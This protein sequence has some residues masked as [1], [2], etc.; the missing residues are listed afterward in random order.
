MIKK[1]FTLLFLLISLPVCAEGKDSITKEYLSELEKCNTEQEKYLETEE[2][3]TNAGMRNSNYDRVD[4]YKN[5]VYNIL[6][7]H[8]P[9]YTADKIKTKFDNYV[10]ATF[11]LYGNIYLSNKN[12]PENCGTIF[13]VV[14]TDSA[15]NKIEDIVKSFIHAIDV[16]NY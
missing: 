10:Q 12:C 4:C 14:Y 15:A 6:K 8:Y 9:K 7:K 16:T 5:I 11:D 13:F 1:I 2:G 3:M